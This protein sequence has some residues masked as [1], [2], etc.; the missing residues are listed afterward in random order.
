LPSDT[1]PSSSNADRQ[2]DRSLVALNFL[3]GLL[4]GT[5]IAAVLFFLNPELPF[6]TASFIRASLLYGGLLGVISTLLLTLLTRRSGERARRVLPWAVTMVLIFAALLNWLHPAYYSYFLPSGINVRMIKAAIILTLIALACFYTALL[7]TVNRRPY[8]LRTRVGFILLVLASVYFV[9]ERREAFHP[10]TPPP[11]LPSV[12]E[13]EQRPLLL[14]VGLDGA[15]LDA[16]LP[17][18]RQGRLPFFARLIENGA[19]ARLN[20]FPPAR[21]PALWTTLATGRLPYEHGIVDGRIF[22]LDLLA[23][24]AYIK[25]L[26][27]GIGFSRWGTFGRQASP[28]DATFHRSPAL[29]EILD[30]LG[31]HSGSVGWPVTYPVPESLVFAFSDHFFGGDFSPSNAR[32]EEVAERGQLFQV[33][34]EDIDPTTLEDF[35]AR[36]P[37]SLIEAL[38]GDLW[39]ESLAGFLLE[40]GPRVQAVFLMLP[41]LGTISQGHFGGYAAVQFGDTQDPERREAA[42]I[43]TSYYRHLDR[44]LAEVWLRAAEPRILAV[45]SPYGYEAPTGL[46]RLGALLTGRSLEGFSHRAPD[47]VLMLLG[48]GIQPG[49]FLE[50]AELI[51]VFPTL[52]YALGLPIARDLEG[53]VLTS[54]FSST[55]LARQPLTFVPSYDTVAIRQRDYQLPK[56]LES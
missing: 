42:Q 27:R 55:F 24:D 9:A 16:I 40:Q 41:G 20:S 52:L 47:G 49:T 34:P 30:R 14:V 23:P 8:S 19:Y 13:L 56:P 28:T 21:P 26:P 12:I 50:K 38:A 29:W 1:P 10:R 25:L 48:E 17:L 39:R 31:V 36:V 2:R 43:V 46:R 53:R 51:D 3:P 45:V 6:S 54:A 37:Y 44:F 7:H 5:Q 18:A 32:P 35:G 4:A 15:T 11:P 22:P 33:E